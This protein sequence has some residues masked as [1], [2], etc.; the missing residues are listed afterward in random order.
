M[1]SVFLTEPINENGVKLL[2]K[3]A[4]VKLGTAMDK[5]TIIKEAEGCDGILIRSAKITEEIMKSLPNLKIVAKHGIG[6][7]NIDVDAASK[8]GILVVNAPES[9][10]N[11]VAEHVFGMIFALSKNFVEMDN[12]TRN[13]EFSMR[14]KVIST[15]LKGKTVGIIGLGK[16]ALLL[17]KKLRALDVNIIGYDPFV[18]EATAREHE[19]NLVS[20]INEIY[21]Q[22]DFITV[23]VPLNNDTRAMIGLKQ[24][25]MMK[26]TACFIN[27]ARGEIVKEK[28]L[29]EA[30][31]NGIIKAAAIDVFEK[32]PP[33]NDNPL[34][35]LKNILL[36]P[37]NAALA[38]EALVNMAVHSAQGIFDFLDG[39]RPKYMVNPKVFKS[40]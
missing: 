2:E 38:D 20:D 28:D 21:K 19:I 35:E 6:V 25:S 15:E 32:E 1:K 36:S 13:G 4:T 16:I 39:K 10:I 34:F 26:K 24:F 11:A 8:L 30:L 31:K 3:I 23:N 37:H 22:G 29:Y 14:N 7:D 18:K 33:E 12:R 9:N 5:D 40:V 27:A 17:V